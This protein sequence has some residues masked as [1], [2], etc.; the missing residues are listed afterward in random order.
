[1]QVGRTG[2]LTPVAR[3]APVFVG[4]VTVTNVTLHNEDEIR[5]KDVRVG[6]TVIVRRAGDVIPEVVR[7]LPEKRPP[8]ACEFVMPA[9]ARFAA[10]RSCASRTRRSP[11]AVAA[12]TARRSASRRCC[13]SPRAG[14]WTSKD[15]ASKLVEQLVEHASCARR[16]TSTDSACWRSCSSNGWPEVGRQPAGGDREEQADDAGALHLRARHPQRR[17]SDGARARPAFRQPRS[18]ARRR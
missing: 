12:S 15:S 3:L 1:M 9:T 11:A 6:D 18:P 14:R 2:A 13:T 10:R 17:R 4:G 8:A 16:P 5:R 7:V